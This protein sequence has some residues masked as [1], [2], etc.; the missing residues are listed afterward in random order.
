MKQGECE[1]AVQHPDGQPNRP[2]LT[3]DFNQSP[4]SEAVEPWFA[5]DGSASNV[6]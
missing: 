5:L 1:Y 2:E 6:L 4:S 3:Q